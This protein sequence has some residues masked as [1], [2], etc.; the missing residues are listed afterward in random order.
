MDVLSLCPSAGS[1]ASAQSLLNY[2]SPPLK[3]RLIDGTQQYTN[4]KES[5]E[6][7]KKGSMPLDTPEPLWFRPKYDVTGRTHQDTACSQICIVSKRA[8]T[9]VEH[10]QSGCGAYTCVTGKERSEVEMYGH[11]MIKWECHIW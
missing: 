2:K 5:N 4:H 7:A 3:G 11:N 9:D 10:G 6:R 1:A 8:D